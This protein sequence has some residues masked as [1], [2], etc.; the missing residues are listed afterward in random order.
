M[1]W[2]ANIY[3]RMIGSVLDFAEERFAD[4]LSRAGNA[5]GRGTTT[6]LPCS[7]YDEIAAQIARGAGATEIPT[8]CAPR[9]DWVAGNFKPHHGQ[10]I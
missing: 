8:C 10:E 6:R 3:E 5:T 7:G 1:S 9:G 2:L 4:E